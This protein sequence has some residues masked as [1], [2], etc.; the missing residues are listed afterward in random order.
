MEFV[1]EKEA[2]ENLAAAV[3]AKAYKDYVETGGR[4]KYAKD[5]DRFFDSEWFAQLTDV[6]PDAIRAMA[7]RDI[8]Y[9]DRAAKI[10]A[11]HKKLG[12]KLYEKYY[13]EGIVSMPLN[14]YKLHRDH[15]VRIIAKED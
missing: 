6:S 7:K 15:Y 4:G 5:A 11:I 12:K 14:I 10:G 3:V 2:Y 1:S 9:L 13:N 8:L